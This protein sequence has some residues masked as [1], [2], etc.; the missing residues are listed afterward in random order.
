MLT[1]QPVTETRPALVTLPA[2]IDIANARDVRNQLTTAVL[3]PGVQVVIADMTATTFC[4][5]TGIRALVLAHQ[6]AARNG[7]E[8]RLLRPRPAVMRLL[9]V[10]GLSSW[11][12][13][14]ETVGDAMTP[15]PRTP[16]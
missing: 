12:T 7:T 16:V 4:D 5:S 11:L 2:E 6:R 10:L 15:G 14:C 3:R 9:E 1:T 8:L 13:I